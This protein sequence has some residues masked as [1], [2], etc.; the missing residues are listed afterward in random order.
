VGLSVH[1]RQLAWEQRQPIGPASLKTLMT[2]SCVA[3]GGVSERLSGGSVHV[4]PSFTY[5]HQI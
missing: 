3:N 5:A 4:Q 1:N 2:G